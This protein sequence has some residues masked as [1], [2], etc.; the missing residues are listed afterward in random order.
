VYEA[1]KT[2]IRKEKGVLDDKLDDM[3]NQVK[4]IDG[5]I[6]AITH[7]KEEW[8]RKIVDRI[9]HTLDEQMKERIWDLLSKKEKLTVSIN[10]I[11][12]CHSKVKYELDTCTKL[13]LINKSDSVISYMKGISSRV[14]SRQF[15]FDQKFLEFKSDFLPEYLE[16]EFIIR[17]YTEIVGNKEIIYSEELENYGITWRLK[18]YPNGNG[19]AKGNY[20]SVFLE[21]VKGYSSSAKYDY[22][23]E[24][25]NTVNALN[26]VSREYTSEFEVG[27]C[28]GY[29]RFYRTE[30]IISEGFIGEDNT[31]RLEFFVRASSYT[32]HWDDQAKYISRLES[33]VAKMESAIL[34]NDI[35]LSDEEK[36]S[37]KSENSIN[38]EDGLDKLPMS[39][40]KVNNEEWI[41]D[42]E[43]NNSE[44][45][46]EENDSQDID[47][48]NK[49]WLLDRELI[50][51]NEG[52]PEDSLVE[53]IKE[54]SE[55][56]NNSK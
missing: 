1:H 15:K 17:N 18:V 5:H 24:M 32:Q 42:D 2:I 51:K 45:K 36:E 14:V 26:N 19:Q 25:E 43:V 38:S 41:S 27:E 3:L 49:N 47:T 34:S 11:E 20:L 33:K 6:D 50:I 39:E 30:A 12:E 35:K 48:I 56:I 37:E 40:S 28:W 55:P 16:G 21:M 52:K 10:K 4:N 46:K 9:H 8:Y 13:K 44:E 31:L 23:I 7:S 54:N 22:K 53:E 29:N